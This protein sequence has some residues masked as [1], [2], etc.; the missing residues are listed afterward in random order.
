MSD[1]FKVAIIP[2]LDQMQLSGMGDFD[3][4]EV[5]WCLDYYPYRQ[6]YNRRTRDDTRYVILDNGAA[7]ASRSVPVNAIEQTL[8]YVKPQEIVAPDILKQG[9]ESFNMSMQFLLQFA[10]TVYKDE[11]VQYKI[12]V[13]PQGKD[14]K[15]WTNW[16]VRTIGMVRS[17]EV[18]EHV[19][20]GVPKWLTREPMSR[21]EL[22][23][24]IDSVATDIDHHLLGGGRFLIREVLEAVKVPFLRGIDTSAPVGLALEDIALDEETELPQKTFNPTNKLAD[25]LILARRN[26]QELLMAAKGRV[27]KAKPDAETPPSEVRDVPAKESEVGAGPVEAE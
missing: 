25:H 21:P 17:L 14:Y 2:T 27:R 12:M 3:L 11:P 8:R 7:L 24:G 5:P 9:P 10:L 18:A 15:D 1:E 19:V 16:Y 26:C 6:Y 4:V 13:A 22:L 20:I 23:S